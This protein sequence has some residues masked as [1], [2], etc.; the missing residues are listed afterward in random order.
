VGHAAVEAT[1]TTGDEPGSPAG[2]P[3]GDQFDHPGDNGRGP[4]QR[5]AGTQR[6][7]VGGREVAGPG[8]R[9]ERP[10]APRADA[11][12]FAPADLAEIVRLDGLR[13]WV[14]QGHQQLKQ[15]P[16]W[17][18][19]MVRADRAIRRHRYLA[20]CAFSFCWR[21][22]FTT[23]PPTDDRAPPATTEAAA[24][25]DPDPASAPAR[26]EMAPAQPDPLRPVSWPWA[27]RHVRGWPDPWIF[28]WC[29]RRARSNAP[30]PPELLALLESVGRGRPHDLSL[31]G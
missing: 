22:R 6:E 12:P 26:G 20:F 25:A 16:G 30:P 5:H 24:P 18:D 10:G 29:C 14:G 15:A 23:G 1:W 9:T 13:N 28:L 3:G 31:R 17:S 21:A 19:C 11:A 8:R 27:L 7:R 4:R 2:V